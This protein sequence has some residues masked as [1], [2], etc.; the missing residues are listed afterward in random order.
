MGII[1]LRRRES[2]STVVAVPPIVVTV[3]LPGIRWLHPGNMTLVLLL[4]LLPF[5]R[6]ETGAPRG[7]L[8]YPKIN[9]CTPEKAGVQLRAGGRHALPLSDPHPFYPEL[10]YHHHPVM[11][12]KVGQV[13]D[14]TLASPAAQ[15]CFGLMRLC[16][17]VALE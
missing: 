12:D 3:V 2:G 6:W 5:C 11:G 17:K 13:G 9:H 1:C 16:V 8:T 4:L 14:L 7:E 15:V 10:G